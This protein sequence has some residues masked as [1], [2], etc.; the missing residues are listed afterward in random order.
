MNLH[1]LGKLACLTHSVFVAL[2]LA[3]F[4]FLSSLA[5]QQPQDALFQETAVRLSQA[6]RGFKDEYAAWFVP[7]YFK[8]VPKERLAAGL[9][10]GGEALGA[11]QRTRIIRHTAPYAAELEFIGQTHRR[12]QVTLRMEP[13]EP[14]RITY[15]YFTL[16]DP[17]N[18]SWDRLLFELQKLPG[19]TGASVWQ[20]TPRPKSLLSH[21]A[22]VPLAV[23]SSFKLLLL[24][25]LADEIA[26][27]KR[28]WSD[29][30]PLREEYRSLPS[31]MLHEWPAGSP[32]T[33]HTLATMM[34]ARS[35]NTAADHLFHTL[36]RAVLEQYLVKA[37]VQAPDR[38]RPFLC[39]SEL[40]KL[41]L[42]EPPETMKQYAEARV[43]ERRKIVER[44]KTVQLTSPRIPS[45][46]AGI[47]QVEWF[48]T[49]DD[50]CRLLD[51]FRTSKVSKDV[52]PLLAITRPY[53]VDDYEWDY[54]GFKGGAEAGVLNL[55]LLARRKK[56]GDWF[57]FSFTW[58]RPDQVLDEPTWIRLLERA[59]LLAEREV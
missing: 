37:K 22:D 32:M 56:H 18:D 43:P 57:V 20:L 2:T 16:Y 34:I 30:V 14:H 38:N 25:A 31:G 1:K 50:L 10:R 17:G 54:L 51:Q 26:A 45:K 42:V 21:Q 13:E 5:A 23:G 28:K 6:L 3:L 47:D 59:V 15:L 27:G 39:T 12:L 36:G 53:D 48:F 55:S 29:V 44:L 9:Q 24:S 11:L 40:F 4:L 58:N 35:D 7:E 33:L 49:T 52:L 46:P 8:N 41:K 19:Q